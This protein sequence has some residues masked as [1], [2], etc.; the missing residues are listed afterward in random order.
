MKNKSPATLVYF[1]GRKKKSTNYIRHPFFKKKNFRVLFLIFLFVLLFIKGVILYSSKKPFDVSEVIVEGSSKFVNLGD[2]RVLSESNVLNK[3]IFLLDTDALSQVLLENFLALKSVNVK[4]SLPNS[5]LVKIEERVP[6]CLI[7]VKGSDKFYF[8]DEEG[9]VLGLA[10]KEDTN[11]P[12]IIY[13]DSLEVG[14][15]VKK[16]IVSYYFDLIEIL[17]SEGVLVEK[18]ESFPRYVILYTKEGVLVFL[19]NKSSAAVQVKSLVKMLEAFKLEGKKPK[20]VDLR[21]D[22]VIVEFDK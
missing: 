14:K 17:D 22:K 2:I 1:L 4:K 12:V 7:N 20:K 15:F 11:L 19:P 9:F 10:K 16:E 18:I 3:N 13:S 21:F 8:V 6:V 5:I